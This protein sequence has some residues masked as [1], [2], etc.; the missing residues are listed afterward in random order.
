MAA[1]YRFVL[2][3]DTDTALPVRYEPRWTPPPV[4]VRRTD[5]LEL[6]LEAFARLSFRSEGAFAWAPALSDNPLAFLLDAVSDAVVLR[7]SSGRAV[8]ANPSA[9]RMVIHERWPDLA[10]AEAAYE[11]LQAED[12]QY[13]RRCMSFSQGGETFVLEVLR[14]MD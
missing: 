3:E 1:R 8:Y 7:S 12:G 4:W 5:P 11:V 6:L 13:E 2:V 9:R 14:R 10:H